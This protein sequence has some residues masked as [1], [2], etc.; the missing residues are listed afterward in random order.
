MGIL[1]KVKQLLGL[2]EIPR[3]RVSVEPVSVYVP[4]VSSVQSKFIDPRYPRE[5]LL[6]LEKLILTNPD[7][8]HAHQIFLDLAATDIDIFVDT[9]EGREEV[10]KL[11]ESLN[12]ENLARL[13]L[14]QLIIN[15]AISLEWIVKEDLTGVE[16][17]VR[18]PVSTVYFVYD[19][20]KDEFQPYQYVPPKDP[21]KLNPATYKYYP[22]LTL[23]GSPYGIPPFIA[24]FSVVETQQAIMENLKAFAE[25][26][27]LI[28][29]VDISVPP[30]QRLPGE[31]EIEYQK[32]L[33]EYLEE[34]ADLFKEQIQKGIA[35]HYDTTKVEYK[36]IAGIATSRELIDLVEQWMV[37]AS[38]MQPSLLGRTTGSTETWAT[39]AYEQ[40]VRQ[41]KNMQNLCKEAIEYG[42]K[43]HLTLAGAPFSE[44]EV[45]FSPPPSL[46]PEKEAQSRKLDADRIVELAQAGLITSEEA[47]KELGYDPE[48]VED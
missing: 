7:L 18:V 34:N 16:K 40:F 36:E 26:M 21:I 2:K 45:R 33:K 10:E 48:E 29:F 8:A 15:G 35:L 41:L 28:G 44:L 43:L 19:E 42:L 31:T 12:L 38:K 3:E 4:N 37:S 23:D 27:G 13:L 5:F 30:P 22:L 20:E 46:S 47:R 9:D 11:N 25:K 1:E 24:A 17:A 14:S 39:I 32:R 6:E